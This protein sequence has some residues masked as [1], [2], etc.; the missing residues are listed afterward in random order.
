MKQWNRRSCSF[1]WEGGPLTFFKISEGVPWKQKVGNH[2]YRP[3]NSPTEKLK[4]FE[5][6][7][8]IIDTEKKES[9][10]V[11]DLSCDLFNND[12]TDLHI[13]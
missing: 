11:W 6:L 10:I 4:E 9:I 13:R 2:W 5:K 7:L 3:P 1:S 12:T 8:Q